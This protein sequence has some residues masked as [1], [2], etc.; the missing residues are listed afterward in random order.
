MYHMKIS[1]IVIFDLELLKSPEHI[2]LK[3]IIC[4]DKKK[5]SSFINR[6]RAIITRGLYSSNP[7]FEVQN[8]LSWSFF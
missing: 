3:R 7:L 2:L 4:L 1:N 5:L 6:T 8:G